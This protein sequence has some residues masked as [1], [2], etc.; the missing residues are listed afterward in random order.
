LPG[1]RNRR[2]PGVNRQQSGGCRLKP[3]RSGSFRPTPSEPPA[4]IREHAVSSG[5]LTFDALS[6]PPNFCALQRHWTKRTSSNLFAPRNPTVPSKFQKHK[7][8]VAFR[9]RGRR[10]KWCRDPAAADK[11]ASARPGAPS[12][13]PKRRITQ[14]SW[15]AM[16]ACDACHSA[17]IAFHA[18]AGVARLIESQ[19]NVTGCDGASGRK[20]GADLRRR[21]LIVT[22]IT[23]PAL[24]VRRYSGFSKRLARDQL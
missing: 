21:P 14:A 20:I 5:T 22:G 15:A 18:R 1:A 13:W 17:E 7:R 4:T 6:I 11:Q 3:C 12:R 10:L 2:R 19:G 9:R 16:S 23:G 24:R 8:S